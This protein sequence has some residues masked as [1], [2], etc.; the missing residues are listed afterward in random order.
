MGGAAGTV[1][2]HPAAPHPLRHRGTAIGRGAHRGLT[3]FMKAVPGQFARWAPD[4]LTLLD[5]DGY[6]LFATG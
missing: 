5:T 4:L 6:G 1:A 2:F 3:H